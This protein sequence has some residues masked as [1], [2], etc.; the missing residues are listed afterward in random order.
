MEIDRRIV[1]TK[2]VT[3]TS[4]PDLGSKP[5]LGDI[6]FKVNDYVLPFGSSFDPVC[7]RMRQMLLNPGGVELTFLEFPMFWSNVAEPILKKMEA[8]LRRD[9][10]LKE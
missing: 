9:A 5:D 6:L 8:K 10:P 3:D 4:N 7:H 2:N 1:V